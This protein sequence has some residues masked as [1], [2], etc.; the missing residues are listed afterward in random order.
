MSN[1]DGCS[2]FQFNTDEKHKI[3]QRMKVLLEYLCLHGKDLQFS[4]NY[5]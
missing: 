5:T 2:N 3:I 4:K 1:L